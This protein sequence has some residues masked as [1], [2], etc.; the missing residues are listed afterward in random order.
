[1]TQE[2]SQLVEAVAVAKHYHVSP[3][4]VHRLAS[5]GKIPSYRVGRQRRFDLAEVKAALAAA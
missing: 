2:P 5:E 3:R 4:T 1:M